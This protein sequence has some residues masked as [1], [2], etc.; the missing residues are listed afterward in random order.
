MNYYPEILSCG[1]ARCLSYFK[2]VFD[3][4]NLFTSQNVPLQTT[5]I[6]GFRDSGLSVEDITVAIWISAVFN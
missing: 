2:S 5:T 3:F 6:R 1:F 4:E